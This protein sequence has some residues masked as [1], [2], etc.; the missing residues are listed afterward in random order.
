[1]ASSVVAEFRVVVAEVEARLYVRSNNI[2]L[3]RSTFLPVLPSIVPQLGLSA[4]G[5]YRELC[6][7]P[8]QLN[9]LK[10]AGVQ[11][12]LPTE[13]GAIA[14]SAHTCKCGCCK[15]GGG[16]CREEKGRVRYSALYSA[17]CDGA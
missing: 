14:G 2:P 13:S 17:W 7:P 8:P 1:V 5:T 15:R 4:E 6:P 9:E 10:V 3:E 11:L 12:G 16:Q